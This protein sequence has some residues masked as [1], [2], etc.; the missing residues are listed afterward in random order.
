METGVGYFFRMKALLCSSFDGNEL[1]ALG[2]DLDSSLTGAI[3]W[4]NWLGFTIFLT[5]RSPSA[6][7]SGFHP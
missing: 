6:Q 3:S 4:T 5:R 7:S 1:E 2:E